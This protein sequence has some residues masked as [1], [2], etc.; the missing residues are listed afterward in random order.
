MSKI[1]IINASPRREGT[2]AMFCKSCEE[3]LG[4]ET[5]QLYSDINSVDWIM[6]KINEADTIIIS[7]PCYI[8]TYPAQVVYLLEELAK[9][10]EICHGQKVY[11]IINGGMPYVHTHDSGLLML[12]LFC[13]ECN[14][15]YQGGFVMGLGPLL[16]GKPLENHINA[17][18]IVPAFHEFL[19]H[20]KEGEYS[21]EQLYINA[22]L[23]VPSIVTRVLAFSMSKKIDKNLKKHGF[24]C[25]QPSPYW[26]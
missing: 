7:G 19:K 2:S 9:H 14:M 8:D 25:K 26:D 22:E 10:P 24:D 15:H 18:K 3:F 13:K 17:K 23:K 4:G 12:K 21:P 20:V 11:G 16:N 1:L 5:Y 6:P